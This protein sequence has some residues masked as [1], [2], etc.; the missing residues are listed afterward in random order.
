MRTS[1][2]IDSHTYPALEGGTNDYKGV[3]ASFIYEFEFS[4]SSK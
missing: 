4:I 1:I 3:F 2:S